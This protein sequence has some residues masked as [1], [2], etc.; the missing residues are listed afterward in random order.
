[1]FSEGANVMDLSLERWEGATAAERQAIARQL[2]TQLPAGFALHSIRLFSLGKQHHVALYQQ[3]TARFA[4]IPGG[5]VTLGYNADRLWKLNPEELDSWQGTADEY[6]IDK[7]VQEYVAEVTLRPR[8]ATLAP[9][10]IETAAGELGWEPIGVDGP[11]V[12]AIIREHGSRGQVEVVRG[13]ASTRVRRADDGSVVAE[14]SLAQTHADLAARLKTSGFR[15]PTSDEWEYACGCG[16]PTLF[17]WG[18]HVPCDRYPTDISPEEAAWRRRW[19]LS[20]GELDYPPE[21]FA[22]DWDLHR[23][24]NA[25]GLSI[26]FDPYKCELVAEIGTTRGGDGGC[27]ICGGAGF[28]IGWLTLATAYFEEHACKRDPTQPV[29]HG[30]TVGRRVL[31]LR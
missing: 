20:A 30:Y 17:R 13:E 7:T 12:Q 27:T 14:R 15:F 29:S 11:E 16:A 5:P 21:G 3:G 28:F 19:V 18:D 26:A 9:F 1:L 6:G 24:P 8:Q 22:P 31:E 25:F 4:L 23:R 10:L 2:G